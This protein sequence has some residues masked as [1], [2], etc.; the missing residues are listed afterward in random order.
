MVRQADLVETAGQDAAAA[1]SEP[2]VIIRAGKPEVG[3]ARAGRGRSVGLKLGKPV[4]ILKW[5]GV[6]CPIGY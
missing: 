3:D 6:R 1:I 4:A 2:F 5:V